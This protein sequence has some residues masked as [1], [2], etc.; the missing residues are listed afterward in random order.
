MTHS[1]T[2]FRSMVLLLLGLFL[3]GGSVQAAHIIGGEITYECLGGDNYLF[4]MKIYR[5]CDGQGAEFDG[6]P[7]SPFP[8]TVTLFQGNSNTP[9]SILQLGAPIITEIEPD[10]SNPCL[11]VPPGVCVEEGIYTF[12]GSLPDSPESY[13]ITY[14]RC[15]RNN[16]ITNIIDPG[17]VGATYT[18]ELLPEAQNVC[19]S[20]PTF[21]NFPPIV[22]CAGEPI[23]F[24]F[25]ASDPDG[26]ELV[27]SLCAPFVGGGTDQNMPQNPNGVAPNPDLPPPYSQVI[28]AAPAYTFDAPLSANPPLQ[29]DPNTGFI[30]G[31]PQILGQFVV[32]VCVEEYRNG[33]LLSVLRRDFQFNVADCEPTV[34]ADIQE[35]EIINGEDF[36]VIS[37]GENTVEFI[38]ESFQINNIDEYIWEFDLGNG[39]TETVTTFDA[40]VTFPGIGTYEGQLLLNPGTTCSD[41][42]NIFVEIY[43]PV[44][45]QFDFEYD[46]CIS[47][48]VTFI[49]QS[50]SD[51]GPNTIID[52]QWSFGDGNTSNEQ[53]PEHLYQI[54]GDLPIS[55]S[56]TDI[57][58]C[59]DVLTDPIPY[60][61]V[62]A[63]VVVAPSEVVACQPAAI[64]LNNLSI[65]IDSTYDIIWDFG[66]GTTGTGVS[67]TH[68]Y[69]DPGIFTV[70]VEITSP[71]GC[72]A[73]EVFPNLVEVLPSPVAGFDFNPK[74]PSNLQPT[75]FFEDQSIDAKTW[76]WNFGNLGGSFDPSPVYTF[77]DTG[78]QVVTQIVTHE[79]GCTDTAVA[80]LDVIP[81][82]R[83]FLPNAFTPNDDGTNDVFRG[84]GFMDGVTNFNFQIWNRY[85]EL[86]FE[87]SD[88]FEAW[89]GRKNNM[90]V[91]APQG[92]YIVVVRYTE[93]RGEP[94]ELKGY[95]TLIR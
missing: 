81:E 64:F 18:M 28:F 51:A 7:G 46:T 58:G 72:F 53:N 66:D 71:I 52:W 75:V 6:A 90:G 17:N 12:Q 16:T 43:P 32:G 19:N 82:I 30:T 85:G 47:G 67:P 3:A 61:P 87:T 49:D 95:A 62:P 89:N 10:I 63:L 86:V 21:N 76:L 92:V 59:E 4:T 35:D 88:P 41:T 2:Y 54:P 93:P 29:I 20:S 50:F 22:I 56:V 15:C 60:F 45:S 38:N 13:H 27:Y 79:S 78:F 80:I 1:T 77:P 91:L 69:E 84:Q 65:P 73:S 9:L 26:D 83:Y 24:D 31:V 14:Q 68:I 34:V 94:V 74:D 36:L 70:S 55:L 11:I 33:E 48:P 57:N 8:A 37:C 39:M 5:D 44:F 25:S 40:T 42:A 23:D